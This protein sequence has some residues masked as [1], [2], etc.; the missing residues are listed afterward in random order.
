[1]ANVILLQKGDLKK[2]DFTNDN[3]NNKEGIGIRLS[4]DNG[5]LLQQRK[6]GL[7]YGIEAP[8]DTANLYVSSTMGDDGNTG[9]RTAPLKTIREAFLRNSVGTTFTVHLYENDT[10][11][12]LSSWGR[13]GTGKVAT[14]KPYGDVF[15][16]LSIR[17]PVRSYDIYRC[18]ELIRPV[19]RLVAD[20]SVTIGNTTVERGGFT[21]SNNPISNPYVLLGI[22]VDTTATADLPIPMGDD[23]LFGMGTQPISITFVGCHLR[24]GSSFHTVTEGGVGTVV[25]DSV[26]VDS[27]QGNKLLRISSRGTLTLSIEGTH[28]IEGAPVNGTPAGQEP[29]T[30]WATTPTTEY[31]TL[32]HGTSAAKTT[33]TNLLTQANIY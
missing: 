6:N 15:D 16:A 2:S 1:M 19:M 26:K 32:L 7:Y 8:P 10:H 18:R 22:T 29:L 11:D 5:N 27:S 13:F 25:L 21:S 4:S 14:F 20:G 30:Y 31:S 17:N 12:V 9:T 28:R 24:L 33:S 3:S 23:A